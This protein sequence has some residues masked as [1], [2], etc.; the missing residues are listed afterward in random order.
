MWC[1][2]QI[3]CFVCPNIQKPLDI[4]FISYETMKNSKSWHSRDKYKPKQ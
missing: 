2:F 3:A 1:I 4:Q